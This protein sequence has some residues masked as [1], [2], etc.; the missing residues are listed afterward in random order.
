M[1]LSGKS[2]IRTIAWC[3]VSVGVL[4]LP[5]PAL[6]LQE[7]APAL[8]EAAP[9]AAADDAAVLKDLEQLSA[10]LA[11]DTAKQEER[12]EAARRLV[13][14]RRDEARQI[15]RQVLVSAGNRN[16]QLSVARAL[17]NDPKP[18]PEFVVPLFALLGPDR[19]LTE[20][21]AHALAAYKGNPEVL[22][23]LIA[24]ANARQQPEAV[25][26]AAIR[27]LGTFL[28][29][30]AAEALVGLLQNDDESVAV[31]NAAGDAL[32]ELTGLRE[33]GR[34]V[35][36]WQ[37]WWTANAPK[38]EA[39]WKL[40]LL[41]E[42]AARLDQV[43]LR[44]GQL[45]DE[46]RNILSDQYQLV[47]EAQKPEIVLRFLRANEAVIRALGAR[48][49]FEDAVNNRTIPAAAREQLRKMVGDSS[50]EVRIEVAGA[51]RA[52]NDAAALEPLLTQL[53]QES[54]PDVRV[55]LAKAVAPIR[56]LKALPAMRKLLRDPS[57]AV[58]EAAADAIRQ[59]GP[60]LR[61]KEPTMAVQ[62]AADLREV[63]T[64]TEGR[65]GSARLREACV[66]AMV[67]LRDP[68]LLVT[69]RKLLV[70]RESREVR[71]SAL[72]ALGELREPKV[73]EA[74]I[75]SLED[76]DN[77]VRLEAVEALG[78]IGTFEHAEMLYRSLN[79]NLEPDPSVRQRAWAVMTGLFPSAPQEQLADWAD[80][81]K[82]D[83]ERRLVVLKALADKQQQGKLEERLA[84]TRENIGHLLLTLKQPTEAV[85][86]LKQAL[87][88]WNT[89]EAPPIVLQRLIAL[90]MKALLNA[91]Q[92]AEAAQFGSRLLKNDASQ[93]QTVF[94]AFR[95]EAQQLQKDKDLKS[96]LSLIAESKK[97]DPP[98]SP[99]FA[100]D[101]QDIESEIRRQMGETRPVGEPGAGP[102][103]AR[104]AHPL[105]HPAHFSTAG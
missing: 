53:A 50:P 63:L 91:K 41:N 23:R 15:L 67:P 98:L 38:S 96:A 3:A 6:A 74:I 5:H 65:P 87:E 86:Y 1:R 93:Q 20:A 100:R 14:R 40:V 58:A 51:L 2:W 85:V 4:A 89:H 11:S 61:D 101:L 39:D 62:T 28:D 77:T 42:R 56:D 25:R 84:Y 102:Q 59:L 94:V 55:A 22:S 33:N 54:D 82:D 70:A 13:S 52:I 16:G 12:D 99:R 105:V 21:A 72:K 47:P 45:T 19:A 71:R 79:P 75:N 17:A 48:L 34:D 35:Q 49:V 18:D 8:Q 36:K 64:G 88:Y 29:K 31:H 26:S 43:Q 90:E 69:F 46:I 92:Y 95:E 80:R 76:P 9:A 103:S 83:P 32:V 60:Q 57:F 44:Y 7:A 37:Q 66:E 27:S 73:A 81:L 104:R 10:K 24:V 97:M 30:R 68:S 78:K